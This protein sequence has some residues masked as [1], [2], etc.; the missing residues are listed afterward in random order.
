MIRQEKLYGDGDRTKIRAV[1]MTGEASQEAMDLVN[2]A[3]R[4]GLPFLEGKLKFGIKQG[5]VEAV[6]AARRARQ[7]VITPE[8]FQVR[9]EERKEE[10]NGHDEL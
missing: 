5:F 3:L 4:L 2:S 1:L 10:G 7:V 9:V 8:F 6:G